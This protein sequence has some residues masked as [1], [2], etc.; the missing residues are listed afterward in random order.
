MPACVPCR[1]APLPIIRLSIA[2]PYSWP[3]T[4]MS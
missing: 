1:R 4:D 2:W 3:I